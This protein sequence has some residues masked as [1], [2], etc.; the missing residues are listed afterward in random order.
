MNSQIQ[1]DKD[2]AAQLIK[3]QF[4]QWHELPIRPVVNSGWDNRTFHL[5]DAMSIR[6]P[7]SKEYAP[8]IIK[9][10][11]YLPQLA[12]T[13]R[14]CKIT[15]PLALGLPSVQYPW[16]WSI[17]SWINGNTVSISNISS[18]TQFAED[19]G[20]LLNQFQRVDAKN[21]PVA[22]A[23]NFHRGG[24]LSVYTADVE[25]S[26]LKMMGKKEQTLAKQLWT[27]AIA[28]QWDKAPVWVH[29]DIAV[30][31]IL[32]DQGKLCAIIDFGQLAVGDP[33]CDL[34]IAWNFFTGES[35]L[36]F[37]E[38]VALDGNTWMR[39]LGWTFWKTLC[40]P[41]PGTDV[42]RILLDVCS[43]YQQM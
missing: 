10:Y 14:I 13:I 11:D 4:P 30:G 43:D 32:V 34:A 17:N 22:G 24:D 3:E 5:G 39:A 12:K 28:T 23:H 1:I 21:G 31:N 9:E 37:K 38:Q 27:D 18:M 7:S 42:K 29:G 35:R 6:I 26:L 8:Q 16:H 40:W 36:R 19:L 2:L 20:A 33:A 15:T 25:A 41:I